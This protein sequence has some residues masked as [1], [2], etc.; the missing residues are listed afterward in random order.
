M[1]YWGCRTCAAIVVI[2]LA[3]MPATIGLIVWSIAI[4]QAPAQPSISV[5]V[6][7]EKTVR[8]IHVCAVTCRAEFWAIADERPI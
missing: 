8:A 2:A 3:L 4:T 5:R 6:Y 1:S 7:T